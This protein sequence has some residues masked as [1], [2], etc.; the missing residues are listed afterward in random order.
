MKVSS[1]IKNIYKKKEE[2]GAHSLKKKKKRRGVGSS[3][4][5]LFVKRR[6][7]IENVGQEG[8]SRTRTQ[9]NSP[10]SNSWLKI[11]PP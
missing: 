7:M 10:S 11:Q 6:I 9:K 2:K 4:I 1:L 3:L 5:S 8:Q